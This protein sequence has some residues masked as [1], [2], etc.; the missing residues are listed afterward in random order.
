MS[1][2]VA[3]FRSQLQASHAA[4]AVCVGQFTTRSTLNDETIPQLMI[5]KGRRLELW[6]P[7]RNDVATFKLTWVSGWASNDLET[8][9][10]L[11]CLVSNKDGILTID[12][13]LQWE[14]LIAVEGTAVMRTVRKGLFK[15]SPHA[16]ECADLC[17]A[18]QLP[19]STICVEHARSALVSWYGGNLALLRFTPTTSA[20]QTI[21]ARCRTLEVIEPM[22]VDSLASEFDIP[23]SKSVEVVDATFLHS[24]AY[25]SKSRGGALAVILCYPTPHLRAEVRGHE[26]DG[27]VYCVN[28]H[29][30]DGKVTPGTW[31]ISRVPRHARVV[32]CSPKELT[33]VLLV[34]PFES[35]L[36]SSAG[37][38]VASL[39]TPDPGWLAPIAVDKYNSRH[40]VD[41]CGMKVAI[42]DSK[43]SRALDLIT[44]S[45]AS[46]HENECALVSLHLHRKSVGI[47]D[48]DRALREL[49]WLKGD[50]YLTVNLSGEAAIHDARDQFIDKEPFIAGTRPSCA[51]G[52]ALQYS[53]VDG[54]GN[55]L[56]KLV[57]ISSGYVSISQLLSLSLS[58]H[59]NN[60]YP[61][62][63]S[64]CLMMR[65]VA[66]EDQRWLLLVSCT[67]IQKCFRLSLEPHTHTSHIQCPMMTTVE[68]ELP[69][70][71][72][73]A[74]SLAFET[75]LSCH[76]RVL[77]LIHV[78]RDAIF[79]SNIHAAH[80]IT[81]M[82]C[83]TEVFS[84]K[85]RLLFAALDWKFLLVSSAH[86][87]AL[88]RV[89]SDLKLSSICRLN[90]LIQTAAVAIRARQSSQQ[91]MCN[92]DILMAVA[93]WES[94][95][96]DVYSVLESNFIPLHTIRLPA[97]LTSVFCLVRSL[98]FARTHASEESLHVG[99]ADGHV[100]V[101][102]AARRD[103]HDACSIFR[104]GS[105]PVTLN[106]IPSYWSTR[107]ED[108]FACGHTDSAII[109]ADTRP[110]HNSKM[111]FRATPLTSACLRRNLTPL[112]NQ[113]VGTANETKTS[114][115]FVWVSDAGFLLTG[116]VNRRIETTA[117]LCRIP[118][119]AKLVYVCRNSQL[120]VIAARLTSDVGGAAD[121]VA[122]YTNGSEVLL[123]YDAMTLAEV[124]RRHL[125]VGVHA[126]AICSAPHLPIA[127]PE[128]SDGLIDTFVIATSL[129]EV[130][131][132]E[133][134]DS[135][136]AAMCVH[137]AEVHVQRQGAITFC[138]IRKAAKQ[139]EF[140]E[141]CPLG[142]MTLSEP[143]AN[144]CSFLQNTRIVA[145]NGP[146][147]TVVQWV[148]STAAGFDASGHWR[149]EKIEPAIT[150]T[151][152]MPACGH[153]VAL[154]S[155][156]RYIAAAERQF[157]VSI[158][159]F[160]DNEKELTLVA[161]D[162]S[163]AR[164]ISS[165]AII[166]EESKDDHAGPPLLM[167][168]EETN[169]GPTNV[170]ILSPSG[171]ECQLLC[172]GSKSALRTSGAASSE[173]A[174]CLNPQLDITV[175][176]A[177]FCAS[178]IVQLKEIAAWQYPSP[179][180]VLQTISGIK[181][182]VV[183][184][185]C[186]DGGMERIRIFRGTTADNLIE[187]NRSCISGKLESRAMEGG[188]GLHV[189]HSRTLQA[190]IEAHLCKLE[191][192]EPKLLSLL[193]YEPPNP[194]SCTIRP[195]EIPL[196]SDKNEADAAN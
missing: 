15:A 62:L 113:P 94:D 180:C 12:V 58:P 143:C 175:K 88:L 35:K 2:S 191:R 19:P 144:L 40:Q 46:N 116:A 71:L 158:F 82:M 80:K 72:R 157:S 123:I 79:V 112:R 10:T 130:Y 184:S 8:L 47:E 16:F 187:I 126:T 181:S 55:S 188:C 22:K 193:E 54:D 84:E 176:T 3:V 93:G 63:Q 105:T 73:Q 132:V 178:R 104:V 118:G 127:M 114:N 9:K 4:I 23:C 173:G 110:I 153:V 90:R 66:I 20:Q 43:S 138:E 161:A 135:E 57:A 106:V 169:R 129:P 24:N 163:R 147:L 7:I 26:A 37:N 61:K 166:T 165:L 48:Q 194:E 75:V 136:F 125:G 154:A 117:Q 185:M 177:P 44:F 59:A 67:T 50:C 64:P 45:N 160:K 141:V 140:F 196:A 182:K 98:A 148:E 5:S 133:A 186:V 91:N 85:H 95:T 102:E 21:D 109:H 70:E 167:V 137:P 41:I 42:S 192:R 190:Y 124:G 52:A 159:L 39:R 151:A 156:T 25:H 152:T 56:P 195:Y 81:Y 155:C 183:L 6:T 142:S 146:H 13:S 139:R 171:E 162:V 1:E 145:T 11:E 69:R 168:S 92:E 31:R 29:A 149:P 111:M 189:V 100:V 38:V 53:P 65:A 33:A 28:V 101:F 76:S 17:V 174:G 77:G 120:I 115:S 89:D 60:G 49:I 32:A 128:Y 83:A 150:S 170:A 97:S 134:V 30:S 131:D 179:I 172:S 107:H 34:T 36:Y 86:T 14:I 96:V 78:T 74:R 108:V 103:C 119:H 122:G 51:V 18:V 27:C 164:L 87:L 68:V 121:A 99:L